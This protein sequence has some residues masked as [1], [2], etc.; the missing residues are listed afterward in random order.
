MKV[1][2]TLIKTPYDTTN[3]TP[4]VVTVGTDHETNL[5]VTRDHRKKK[6]IYQ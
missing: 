3:E 6:V 2:T 5:T 1:I 4:L